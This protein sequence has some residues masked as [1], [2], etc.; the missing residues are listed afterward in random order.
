MKLD[1]QKYVQSFMG[2]SL[3]PSLGDYMDIP[4]SLMRSK[5]KDFAKVKDR[6]W[7]LVQGWKSNLFS[8]GG[9]EVLIKSVAQTIPTYVMSCFKLP[10]SFCSELS[11]TIPRFW[12]GTTK[13]KKWIHWVSWDKMCWPKEFG[14]LNF[15]D[16]K[17]FNKALLAKQLWRYIQFPNLLVAK[18]IRGVYAQ[19]SSLL[20]AE[21]GANWSYF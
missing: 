21:G 11:K 17:L 20:A 7:K 15:R 9:K 1:F 12:W 19:D 18:V 4:S 8:I 5:S 2:M 13:V 10:S 6:L 14:G 3:V 16:L